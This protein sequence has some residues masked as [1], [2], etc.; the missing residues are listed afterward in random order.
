MKLA[1]FNIDINSPANGVFLPGCKESKAIGMIH[2]GKHTE[3][4]EREVLKRVENLNSRDEILNALDDIR[5]EFL[6]GAFEPL[7]MRAVLR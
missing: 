7:N 3:A 2:C 1:D 5:R 4:Y 6:S